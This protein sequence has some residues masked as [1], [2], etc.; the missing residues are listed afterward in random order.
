MSVPFGW[1]PQENWD[2][3][4]VSSLKHGTSEYDAEVY[5]HFRAGLPRAI[6]DAKDFVARFQEDPSIQA[7]ME[8]ARKTTQT[9]QQEKAF[10]KTEALKA[11]KT[12]IDELKSGVSHLAMQAVL[13]DFHSQNP[14]EES[15]KCRI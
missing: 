13:E 9:L 15:Q 4:E 1:I 7:G 5:K 8:F 2:W 6:A 12:R 14:E 3:V 10:Q 11:K